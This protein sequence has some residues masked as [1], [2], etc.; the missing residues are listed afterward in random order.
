MK[1]SYSSSLWIALVILM[2][3]IGNFCLAQEV[4]CAVPG[5]LG[6]TNGAVWPQGT[7]VKV[8]INP[9]DFPSDEQQRAV[10]SAF[11]IWQ[12]ANPN[13]GVTFTFTT[14]TQSAPGSQLNTY[15]V[16]RGATTTGGDTNIGFSG[17]LNTLGNTTQSAVTVVDSWGAPL[18]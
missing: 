1:G 9:I 2:I 5:P 13:S 15:Y 4:P 14:G 17:S 7:T 18:S 6:R 3:G 11:V 16:Q 10:Q 12:N 8:I